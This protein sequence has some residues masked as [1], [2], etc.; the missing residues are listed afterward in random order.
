VAPDRRAV[1]SPCLRDASVAASARKDG[2]TKGA[3]RQRA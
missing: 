2:Q 3:G 1:H